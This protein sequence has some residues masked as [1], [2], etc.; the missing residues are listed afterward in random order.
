MF[1]WKSLS[2]DFEI[3]DVSSPNYDFLSKFY[4]FT[5]I[6]I[7]SSFSCER[8][9]WWNITFSIYITFHISTI[10]HPK[11]YL[12]YNI[13][14]VLWKI[15]YFSKYAWVCK[16][17]SLVLVLMQ[18]RMQQLLK[19]HYN[20]LVSK[21]KK[22]IAIFQLTLGRIW[23]LKKSQLGKLVTVVRVDSLNIPV[24]VSV[25]RHWNRHWHEWG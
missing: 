9:S 16:H 11:D 7:W 5:I 8:S 14:L 6:F 18:Y 4:N 15:P 3:E 21:L 1:I 25:S 22:I 24:D 19:I 12:I 13:K 17:L 23:K 2:S 10:H 20:Y